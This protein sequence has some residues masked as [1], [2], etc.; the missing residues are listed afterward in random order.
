MQIIQTIEDLRSVRASLG[1]DVGVV[2]T[3][4]ALHAGHMALVRQAKADSDRVLATIFVN[5]T[6]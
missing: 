2:T 6:Q 1:N 3:M 5:P 4:G